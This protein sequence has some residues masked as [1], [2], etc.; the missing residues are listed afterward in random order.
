MLV[1]AAKEVRHSGVSD[2][3]PCN[4]SVV[5]CSSLIALTTASVMQ[6]S[7]PCSATGFNGVAVLLF[8]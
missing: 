2:L 6:A 3:Q 1:Q 5:S 4:V 8:P 7:D